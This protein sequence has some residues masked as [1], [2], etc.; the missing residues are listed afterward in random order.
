MG[1][2]L[3]GQ[4]HGNDG[5]VRNQSIKIMPLFR[6]RQVLVTGLIWFFCINARAEITLS[7][8]IQWDGNVGR[9]ADEPAPFYAEGNLARRPGAK[10]IAKDVIPVRVRLR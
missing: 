9:Y 8:N 6:V 5:N 7:G 10:G 4:T 1:P 3:L 2:A